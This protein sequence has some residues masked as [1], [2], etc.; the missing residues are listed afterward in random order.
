MEVGGGEFVTARPFAQ[1]FSPSF[2]KNENIFHPS[3][4]LSLIP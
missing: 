3:I 2:Q 4:F 1:V